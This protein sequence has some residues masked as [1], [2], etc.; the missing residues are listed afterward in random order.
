MPAEQLAR[1]RH[2]AMRQTAARPSGQMRFVGP[3]G[4][5]LSLARP[6]GSELA[7]PRPVLPG[8]DGDLLPS[9]RCPRS[10]PV[11]GVGEASAVTAD[12][13]VLLAL[14]PLPRWMP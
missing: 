1:R 5:A 3:T 4:I 9:H 10:Y 14:P 8:A 7:G 11:P 13:L 12:G 2:H 6:P